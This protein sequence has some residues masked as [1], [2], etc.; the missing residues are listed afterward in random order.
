MV[1]IVEALERDPTALQNEL[2]IKQII[3]SSV[4]KTWNKPSKQKKHNTT[5]KHKFPSFCKSKGEIA[6]ALHLW[7]LGLSPIGGLYCSCS[8]VC[9]STL[10]NKWVSL[11]NLNMKSS[12]QRGESDSKEKALKRPLNSLNTLF[13]KDFKKPRH[14]QL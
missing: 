7:R 11:Y 14:D 1:C 5:N 12:D 6:K 4:G 2:H 8:D 3:N 13:E 10:L 9:D